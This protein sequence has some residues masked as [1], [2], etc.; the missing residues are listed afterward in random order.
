MPLLFTLKALHIIFVVTW[1]AGLFYIVRLFI[2]HTEANAKPEPDKSVLQNQFKIM[3]KRLWY[4]IT[5]PSMIGT[6]TFGS[7]MLWEMNFYWTSGWLIVKLGFVFGLLIY[8]TYCEHILKQLQKDKFILSSNQLRI[9]N[10]VASLFLV[11]IVFLVIFKNTVDF[12]YG[13]AG[14][15]AFASVLMIAIKLYKKIREN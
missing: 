1:F 4:G 11:A 13:I 10:E 15:I 2:Y 8:H 12:L 5:V 3:E 6:L 7:W 9:F 14:L